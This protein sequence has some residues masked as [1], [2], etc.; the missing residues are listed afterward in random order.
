VSGLN[1][2]EFLTLGSPPGEIVLR[3]TL[4]YLALFFLLRFGRKRAAGAVG[5]SDL[6]VVVIIA[7]AVFVFIQQKPPFFSIRLEEAS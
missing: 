5:L 3:G 6:L 1:W 4:V 2:K 7:D